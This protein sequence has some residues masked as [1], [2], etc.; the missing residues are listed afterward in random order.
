MSMDWLSICLGIVI[1]LIFMAI[2]TLLR[3]MS[4]PYIK[5]FDAIVKGKLEQIKGVPE[6]FRVEFELDGRQF[7]LVELKHE[8]QE[9]RNKVYNSCVLLKAK[10]KTDFT[11]HI[12][13]VL[14]KVSVAGFLESVLFQPLD[15]NCF[16][17]SSQEVKDDFKDFKICANNVEKAKEFLNRPEALSILS[18]MKAQFS[19]YGFLMPFVINRGELII[20]YSLSNRLLDELVFDP[21]NILKH[22]RLLGQLAAY[23]EPLENM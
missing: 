10:T 2:F 7:E 8:V 1:V 13:D 17:M 12:D 4:S 19:V 9:E 5:R 21:R 3:T 20:D 22:A 18:S 23:I 6:A 15:Y 16:P 14:N 11:L